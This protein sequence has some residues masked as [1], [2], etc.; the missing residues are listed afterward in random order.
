MH[1][2]SNRPDWIEEIVTRYENKLYRIALAITKSNADAEDIIQDVFIKLFEK[3]PHF[4]SSNH[5]IAWLIRV[6]VNRCKN[7]LRSHWWKKNTH[8]LETHPAPEGIQQDTM[9]AVLALPA[10]YRTVIHL[11]YYEGYST[12]EIAEMTQ[13]KDSTVRQLLTRARRKLKN[14]LE[15]EIE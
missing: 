13:Q 4:E 9:Q 1:S 8:L 7:H 11:Y 2:N 15:G 10:K 12:K 6:T 3:Q 5:E 14:F